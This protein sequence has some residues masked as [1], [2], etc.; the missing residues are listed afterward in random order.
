MRQLLI[1]AFSILFAGPAMAVDY[2]K[3][4]AMQKAHD[5]AL[6]T[7]DALNLEIAKE[8]MERDLKQACGETP[9]SSCYVE[10]KKAVS[11]DQQLRE[12]LS[13]PRVKPY[14]IKVSKIE[15]DLKKAGCP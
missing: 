6:D 13:D 10:H 2:V 1:T 5:R 14:R 12:V 11:K 4:E 8:V 9:S 7:R 15:A 3:C